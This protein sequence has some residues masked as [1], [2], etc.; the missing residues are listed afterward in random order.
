[1]GEETGPTG[2]HSVILELLTREEIQEKSELPFL[3]LELQ[4]AIIRASICKMSVA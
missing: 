2:Q 1:V 4:V 3:S